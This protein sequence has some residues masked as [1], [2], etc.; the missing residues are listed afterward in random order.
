MISWDSIVSVPTTFLYVNFVYLQLSLWLRVLQPSRTHRVNAAHRESK[1]LYDDG[2]ENVQTGFTDWTGV[3]RKDRNNYFDGSR[4]CLTL[5]HPWFSFRNHL[6]FQL[7]FQA[8]GSCVFPV[9]CGV[10]MTLTD[11]QRALS[12]AIQSGCWVVFD[13]SVGMTTELMS[14]IAQQLRAIM[15]SLHTLKYSSSQQYSIRGFPATDLVRTQLQTL[16]QTI[17]LCPSESECFEHE[18]LYPELFLYQEVFG[19]EGRKV[20]RLAVVWYCSPGQC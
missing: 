16:F 7:C 8:L 9:S 13:G 10:E 19:R 6:Y 3:Y 18:F 1:T 15:T 20:T 11:L 17:P 4:K 5:Y 14:S 12:G 2:H